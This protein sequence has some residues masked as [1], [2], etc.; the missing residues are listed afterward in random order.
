M[1]GMKIIYVFMQRLLSGISIQQLIVSFLVVPSSPSA[2]VPPTV[3][4]YLHAIRE[5]GKAGD[6]YDQAIERTRSILRLIAWWEGWLAA[7]LLLTLLAWVAFQMSLSM[8]DQGAWCACLRYAGHT[9]L[10]SLRTT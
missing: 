9:A 7:R 8:C 10:Q 5:Q 2:V 6:R 3:P 4:G 1:S